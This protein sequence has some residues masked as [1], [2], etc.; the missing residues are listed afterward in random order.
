MPWEHRARGSSPGQGDRQSCAGSSLSASVWEKG[1]AAQ[2][3]SG[4][5]ACPTLEQ[6]TRFWDCCHQE[7]NLPRV[8]GS[9]VQTL[10]LL[11]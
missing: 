8:P 7:Q 9:P 1:R 4:A 2:P 11:P 5:M 3:F 6:E 10:V